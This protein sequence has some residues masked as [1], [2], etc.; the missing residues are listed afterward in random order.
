MRVTSPRINIVERKTVYSITMRTQMV[1][2]KPVAA[3]CE[4]VKM[5]GTEETHPWAVETRR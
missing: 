4:K 3:V 2:A 5:Q 1:G